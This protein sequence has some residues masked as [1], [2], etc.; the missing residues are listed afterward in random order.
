M[1]QGAEL[2]FYF[3]LT[4]LG[5]LGFVIFLVL[6]ILF[7]Q[8]RKVQLLLQQEKDKADFEQELFLVK[9]EIREQNMS[10]ISQ[11]LHDNI[12]QILS[13]ASIESHML[14][15]KERPTNEELTGLSTLIDKSLTELR[16]LSSTMNTD[17]IA[18]KGLENMIS[19]ELMRCCKNLNLTYKF[20]KD[21]L[22]NVD[23]KK[24]LVLFRIFQE[25][26]TNCIKYSNAEHITVTLRHTP[27]RLEFTFKDDGIGFD[28]SKVMRGNGLHN[29]IKRSEILNGNCLI[30]TSHGTSVSIVF[31]ILIS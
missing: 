4:S 31:P 9:D 23:E 2:Q 17:I 10:Y 14:I 20:T 3:V 5:F 19:L 24:S 28:Q 27:E 21:P 11:E 6:V 13:V 29:I 18:I 22:F 26:L 15:D 8:K 30:D 16:S 12:G 7:F 25:C 1:E